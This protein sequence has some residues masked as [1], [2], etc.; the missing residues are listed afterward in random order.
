MASRSRHLENHVLAES[1]VSGFDECMRGLALVH[2]RVS[3]FNRV[4]KTFV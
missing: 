2:A 1:C 4:V 3:L